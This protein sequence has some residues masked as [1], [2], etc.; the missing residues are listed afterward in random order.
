LQ[1]K[2]LQRSTVPILPSLSAKAGQALRGLSP[3][4]EKKDFFP[5]LERKKVKGVFVEERGRENFEE[6][7]RFS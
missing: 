3:K 7:V 5:L 6:A 2:K 1:R 4:R